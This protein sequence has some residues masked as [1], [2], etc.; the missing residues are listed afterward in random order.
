MNRNRKLLITA[1]ILIISSA[2]IIPIFTMNNGVMGI[3]TSFI[4]V[5]II[6]S[7][8]FIIIICIIV[9]HIKN[10]IKLNKTTEDEIA[11]NIKEQLGAEKEEKKQ[12]VTCLY[13]GALYSKENAKCP[14]CGAS[15]HK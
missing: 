7:I 11:D 5:P 4:L 1:V 3:L 14:H 15:R 13:C 6:D 9:S 8:A 2:L 10:N 12:T